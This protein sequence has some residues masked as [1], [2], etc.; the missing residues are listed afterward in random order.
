MSSVKQWI[1]RL[2]G[3]GVAVVLLAAT[4]IY[5]MSERAI[6]RT[7]TFREAPVSRPTDSLSLA[8]GAHFV[9]LSCRGCHTETMQG[10]VMFD[11]PGVARLIAP[12]VLERLARYTDAE[13]AGYMRYGVKKDGSSPFVMPPP[14][15]YHMS[16]ADMG[17]MI[18]YLRSLPTPPVIKLATNSYG[19]LGRLGIVMG[20]F[21]NAASY[22]DTSVAR[23]GVDSMYLT[24]RRGE[25]MARM[26]CGDCHGAKLTGDPATPSPSIA[27][28]SGYDL[29]QF[30]ELIR[31]GT[32]RDPTTKLTLM[33]EVA[34][35]T[36]KRLTDDEIAVIHTYLAALP[37]TGVPGI[38]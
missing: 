31:M 34:R 7:Y 1:L 3:G 28:A 18:A 12:N 17:A 22:I 29:S 4:V 11:Q 2:V 16:D 10:G 25:Y 20:Q 27:S 14:G 26:I 6:T 23:I 5:V 8:R 38:K 32:P 30:I 9:E 15:F 13:F 36:L 19:P 33:A 21:G 35:A 37:Q 24:A